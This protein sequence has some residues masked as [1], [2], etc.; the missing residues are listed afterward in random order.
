MTAFNPF[1]VEKVS[2]LKMAKRMMMLH[3]QT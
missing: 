1:P 2:M 3:R